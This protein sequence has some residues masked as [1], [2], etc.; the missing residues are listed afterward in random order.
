LEHCEIATTKNGATQAN[1]LCKEIKSYG[2]NIFGIDGKPTFGYNILEAFAATLGL[3]GL[4]DPEPTTV[5][6]KSSTKE[7]MCLPD[8]ENVQAKAWVK[9]EYDKF[10]GEI[11]ENVAIKRFYRFNDNAAGSECVPEP[12]NP[13]GTQFEKD[14][15]YCTEVKYNDGLTAEDVKAWIASKRGGGTS[16]GGAGGS[17]AAPKTATATPAAGAGGFPGM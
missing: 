13:V 12:E 17:A 7:L 4:R 16:G 15:K 10:N 6:F 3:D 14:H 2:N 9:F 5:K 11:R 8:L 1:Y